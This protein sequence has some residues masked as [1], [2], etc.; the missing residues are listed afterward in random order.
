MAR[1]LNRQ[2][3]LRARS[4]AIS[5]AAVARPYLLTYDYLTLQRMADATIQ[6]PDLAYVVILDKE[7]KVAGYGGH[8]DQQGIELTSLANLRALQAESP[9]TQRVTF[10]TARGK[11]GPGDRMLGAGA[12]RRAAGRALGHGA[13]R[14]LPRAGAARD[15]GGA[16]LP[17]PRRG[18]RDARRGLRLARPGAPHHPA[19]GPAGR[20]RHRD[21]A[22]ALEPRVLRSHRG[23]DRGAGRPLRPRR[24]VPRPAEEGAA[25]GQGGAD[26]PQRHPRGE[27]AAAHRGAGRLP[28]EVPAPGGG[29]PRRLRAPGAGPDRLRQPGLP[30][31]LPVPAPTRACWR[32]CAGRRSST[33]TSTAWPAITSAGR[34]SRWATSTPS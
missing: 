14:P 27:G 25:G 5:L 22:R 28:R 21:G 18:L 11:D 20:R 32:T 13:G 4:L 3:E 10:P 9:R 8:R 12:R 24:R 34:R 7:G 33:P 15:D 6:E 19:A 26:R 1:I 31:D 30:E 29:K 17:A 16:D 23:R 2:S